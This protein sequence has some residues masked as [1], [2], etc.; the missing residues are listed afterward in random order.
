[1][2]IPVFDSL[3]KRKKTFPSV[4]SIL[5]FFLSWMFFAASHYTLHVRAPLPPKNV[6]LGLESEWASVFNCKFYSVQ[7]FLDSGWYTGD[8]I[9]VVTKDSWFIDI[10]FPNDWNSFLKFNI[11][12]P[13]HSKKYDFTFF[14]IEL[15]F[16]TISTT[17]SMK[18]AHLRSCVQ[19]VFRL[20][21]S[22]KTIVKIY[23]LL[24]HS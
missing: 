8:E 19:Q 24:I 17:K 23:L 4:N 3:F 7:P 11:T 14:K 18:L 12:T 1:M 20:Y 2:T 21:V 22:K 15:K 6:V 5:I 13:N 10:D 16:I 9:K